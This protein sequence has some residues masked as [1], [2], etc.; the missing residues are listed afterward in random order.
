[1]AAKTW[2]LDEPTIEEILSDPIVQL[3][4]RRDGVDRQDLRARLR[5]IGAAAARGEETSDT[6]SLVA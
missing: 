2:T 4:M 6:R 1:M 3:L 5:A